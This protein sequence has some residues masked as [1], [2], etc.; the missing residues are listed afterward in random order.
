VDIKYYQKVTSYIRVA[1]LL[2]HFFSA[3]LAQV[4]ISTKLLDEYQLNFL[5]LG[6]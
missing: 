3:V 4:F 6:S 5:T 1:H 2:G